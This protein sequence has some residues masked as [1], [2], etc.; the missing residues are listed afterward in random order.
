[1]GTTFRLL[2][3]SMHLKPSFTTTEMQTQASC[4]SILL[5]MAV[6]MLSP[7]KG[8]ARPM[9][10]DTCEAPCPAPGT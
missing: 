3:K 1:M 9:G 7:G 5:E 2:E 6:M 8:A 10:D 4:S